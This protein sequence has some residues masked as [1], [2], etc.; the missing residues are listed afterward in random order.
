MKEA[1]VAKLSAQCEDYYAEASKQM[2]SATAALWDKEWLPKVS[3]KQ[4]AYH[5]IAQ[6]YQSRVCSAKKAV[7]E[8]IARL[9]AAIESFKLAQQRSSDT[10]LYQDYLNRA[11]KAH[12]DAQKDNDFIYH[13][14]VPEVKN[15]E[16]VGKGALAKITM[17]PERLSNNFKGILY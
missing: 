17:L 14:R 1:I 10:S 9:Q 11:Q 13:E 8:E 7:G 5:A 4:A 15:L 12:A 6:F 2:K 16:P 3:A